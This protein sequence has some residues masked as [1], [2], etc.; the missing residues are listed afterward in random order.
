MLDSKGYADDCN[1]EKQPPTKMGERD[2]EASNEPPYDIHYS[3]KTTGGPTFVAYV[4]SKRP[5]CKY[6]QLHCLKSERN[7]DDGNHHDHAGYGIFNGDHQTAKD[8]PYYVE[9]NIH[10]TTSA[11]KASAGLNAGMLWAGTTTVVFLEMLRASFT[12]LCF[13]MKLPKPRRYTFSPCARLSLIEVIR[14]S[15]TARA[16]AFSMPVERDISVTISAFVMVV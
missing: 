3:G 16:L 1:A 7:A 10:F 15:T 14:P 2:S 12:A 9:K 13:T 5:Q 8:Y 4:R 6:R 11:L